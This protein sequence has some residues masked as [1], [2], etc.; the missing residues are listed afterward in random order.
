MVMVLKQSAYFGTLIIFIRNLVYE[1]VKWVS[2][3]ENYCHRISSL[4]LK[5]SNIFPFLTILINLSN[6]KF[7]ITWR[8][9]NLSVWYRINNME[10]F[11]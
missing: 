6:D 2:L 8:L 7:K 10:K 9:L 5:R 1:N 4:G 11:E 3:A